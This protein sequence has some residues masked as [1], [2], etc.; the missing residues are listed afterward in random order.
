MQSERET[1]EGRRRELL[2]GEDNSTE[3]CCFSLK[4]AQP[5]VAL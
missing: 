4:P 2:R 3:K 1:R 5:L